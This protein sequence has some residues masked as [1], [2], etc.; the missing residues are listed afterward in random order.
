MEG[1]II[2]E[3]NLGRFVQNPNSPAELHTNHISL[4]SFKRS[5]PQYYNKALDM[6]ELTTSEPGEQSVPGV[7]LRGLSRARCR[8]VSSNLNF[9]LVPF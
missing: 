1:I 4:T 8:A 6:Y 9:L 5:L 7:T 3:V 2:I